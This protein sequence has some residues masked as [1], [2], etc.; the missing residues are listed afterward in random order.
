MIQGMLVVEFVVVNVLYVVD[1]DVV[2]YDEYWSYIGLDVG[3]DDDDN[4][5]LVVVVGGVDLKIVQEEDV[6][7]HGVMMG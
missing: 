3:D 6:V 5:L 1:D 4:V 7:W 2:L